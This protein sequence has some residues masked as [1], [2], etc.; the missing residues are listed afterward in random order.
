M[1]TYIYIYI[2]TYIWSSGL[3]TVIERVPVGPQKDLGGLRTPQGVLGTYVGVLG[4]LAS[5]FASL[6]D[7]RESL[8]KLWEGL[9]E[10]HR[11]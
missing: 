9:L 1:Y 5:L 4:N 3:E 7:P 8:E 2:Y 6:R 11:D 10:A